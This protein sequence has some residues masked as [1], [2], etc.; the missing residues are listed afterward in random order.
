M[1]LLRFVL[2]L[3]VVGYA[4]WLAW[5]FIS[6]FLEGASPDMAGMRAGAEAQGSGDLFGLV[7]AWALWVG[8]VVLYL[9]AALML[10]AGNPKAAIAYFLGFLADAVL[11]LA[12]GQGGGADVSSR[13]A[14]PTMA[15]D[16]M[17]GL[18]LDPVWLVLGVLL[19]VGV[20]VVVAS[21]RVRRGRQ[22]GH[23]GT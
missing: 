10:G 8:A 11:R 3:A 16:S 22:P 20:L 13:S 12:I 17:S 7:P 14:G 21:R 9:V 15:P 6:P 19:I 1:K 23:F 2:V 5:P 4:G 18:P